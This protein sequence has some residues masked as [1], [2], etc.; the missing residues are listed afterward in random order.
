MLTN[1]KLFAIAI[2]SILG[3]VLF[4]GTAFADVKNDHTSG[5][6]LGSLGC[7]DNTSV[8]KRAMEFTAT[9]TYFPNSVQFQVDTT[10]TSTPHLYVAKIYEM[11]SNQVTENE[12]FSATST[13]P[14]VTETGAWRT[15]WNTK[16]HFIQSGTE[17]A[18]ALWEYAEG[19]GCSSDIQGYFDNAESASWIYRSNPSTGWIEGDNDFNYRI[20]SDISTVP[21]ADP[22]GYIDFT[23][24]SNDW[25]RIQYPTTQYP[26]VYYL[27][28][29]SYTFNIESNVTLDDSLILE[30]RSYT[31]HSFSSE[32]A[33]TTYVLFPVN[34]GTALLNRTYNVATTTIEFYKWEIHNDDDGI[35]EFTMYFD[36][37]GD[38]TADIIPTDN[39]AE[40]LDQFGQPVYQFSCQIPFLKWDP[41]FWLD[42]ARIRVSKNISTLASSTLNGITGTKPYSYAFDTY[43]MLKTAS[44]SVSTTTATGTLPF[45]SIK[46]ATTTNQ[47]GIYPNLN[48]NP[49]PTDVFT[50]IIPKDNWNTIRAWGVVIMYMMLLFWI[51]KRFSH[52]E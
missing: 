19:E 25:L 14:I 24:L 6:H 20:R 17:Y 34:H 31:D 18:V 1:I 7:S 13:S 39:I 16:S 48:F 38:I 30:Y 47:A 45:V 42:D 52:I 40:Y 21:G 3:V 12:I 44:L 36:I 33:S 49:I 22:T 26:G 32:T 5:T 10:S 8:L 28:P 11:V 43:D 9:E 27:Y 51:I 23:D 46:T 37:I 29:N 4:S 2:S 35:P 15:F 41:C 50:R